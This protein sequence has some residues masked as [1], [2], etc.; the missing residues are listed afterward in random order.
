MVFDIID[1]ER[2]MKVA[3]PG[4]ARYFTELHLPSSRRAAGTIDNETIGFDP[5][6]AGAVTVLAFASK[7]SKYP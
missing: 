7:L 6:L 4:L 5:V 2:D 1:G 3:R